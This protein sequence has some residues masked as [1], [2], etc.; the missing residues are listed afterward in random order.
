MIFSFFIITSG[1]RKRF[2]FFVYMQYLIYEELENT[3]VLRGYKIEANSPEEAMAIVF[4]EIEVLYITT[5][6]VYV[7]HLRGDKEGN[8]ASVYLKVI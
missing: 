2:S 7:C 5:K 6:K 4:P 3:D 8:R 1:A